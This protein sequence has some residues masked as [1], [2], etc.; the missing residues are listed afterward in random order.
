MIRNVTYE[1]IQCL[2]HNLGIVSSGLGSFWR[3]ASRIMLEESMGTTGPD[4][5]VQFESEAWYPLAG[6]LRMLERIRKDFGEVALRQV[7]ASIPRFARAMPAGIDV[8]AAFQ[9]LDVMYHLNH[10]VNGQPMFSEHTGQLQDGIGHYL[11]RPFA[12][13]KQILCDCT[14]PYPCAFDEGLLLAFARSHEPSAM[15]THLEPGMCR[16]RGAARCTYSVAWT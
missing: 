10:A 4:G 12:R 8:R 1:R 5:L 7:G 14:G 13:H 2:G 3:L 9:R 15:L 6:H 11:A 16:T